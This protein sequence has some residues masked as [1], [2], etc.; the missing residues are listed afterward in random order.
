MWHVGTQGC[1]Q[2]H[3]SHATPTCPLH[4][5][6]GGLPNSSVLAAST[7]D[8]SAHQ[9]AAP[10]LASHSR[11]FA[12]RTTAGK[13]PL[14]HLPLHRHNLSRT[15]SPRNYD[16]QLQRASRQHRATLCIKDAFPTLLHGRPRRLPV[17]LL[18]NPA[19]PAVQSP[20]CVCRYPRQVRIPVWPVSPRPR[21]ASSQPS[22]FVCCLVP[23][24]ASL[25]MTFPQSPCLD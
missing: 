13:G 4:P 19:G 25:W 14:F 20:L 9:W 7:I 8:S 12:H 23:A 24:L 15:L 17:A 1:R 5:C 22:L 18:R 21:E 6:L 11:P 3:C 10:F 16:S 2:G